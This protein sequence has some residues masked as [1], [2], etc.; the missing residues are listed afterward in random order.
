MEP[1]IIDQRT[2]DAS[3]GLAARKIVE[4]L[5]R[6]T[7]A[8]TW[9]SLHDIFVDLKVFEEYVFKAYDQPDGVI[10]VWWHWHQSGFTYVYEYNPEDDNT[11]RVTIHRGK[12]EDWKI[13]ISDV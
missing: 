6:L 4:T 1:I 8:H 2:D 11:Y 9:E 7:N 13:V 12:R 10:T 5:F 3:A